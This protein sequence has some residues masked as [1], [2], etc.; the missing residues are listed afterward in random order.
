MYDDMRIAFTGKLRSGKSRAAIY[1]ATI[2]GFETAS[3]G[4]KL[5]QVA[6]E[7]FE[8]S[9]VYK[10]EPILAPDVFGG[11]YRIG[12]GKP[13]RLYQDFGQAMRQLDADIWI[14][15]VEARVKGIERQAELHDKPVRIVI[16]D[17][18]Q[19]N[20]A[21][22]LKRNGFVIIRVNA[23]D[24]TRLARAKQAGDNFTTDDLRHETEM[25]V[26]DMTA[27][28]EIQNDSDDDLEL[29]R[30]IDEILSEIRASQLIGK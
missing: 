22:W 27:D 28:Y 7:L 29:E 3:F 16:D 1:L 8:H 12:L 19:P 18:R 24:E 13:R 9:N 6:D 26:D 5:K 25:H 23:S 11:T 14:N 21:E 2:H 4:G 15:H 30:Q 10:P 20:E 17:L